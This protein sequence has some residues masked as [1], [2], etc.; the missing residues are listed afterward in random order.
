MESG[1]RNTGKKLLQELASSALR[2]TE[3]GGIRGV[4]RYE[5][6]MERDKEVQGA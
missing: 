4:S 5:R 6:R 2:F 1:A 3:F